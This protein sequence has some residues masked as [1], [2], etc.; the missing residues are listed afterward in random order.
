MSPDTR[1][2]DAG[3]LDG[4]VKHVWICLTVQ[5]CGYPVMT[6][7]VLRN[8]LAKK[9]TGVSQSTPPQNLNTLNPGAW[10]QGAI[11]A[12]SSPGPMRTLGKKC[13]EINL[14]AEFKSDFQCLG[15]REFFGRKL[16]RC[17]QLTNWHR[18]RSC[19]PRSAVEARMG[20]VHA[21]YWE[22]I[23]VGVWH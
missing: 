9:Q 2:K 7:K 11:Q 20:N 5:G 12:S 17:V 6:P 4:P 15:N 21:R 19:S 14:E 13:Q 3:R 16:Y 10:T 8:L 22:T 23:P 18:F 1:C